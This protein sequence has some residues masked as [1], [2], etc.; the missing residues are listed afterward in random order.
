MVLCEDIKLGELE[1]AR[2]KMAF[3]MG[4]VLRI[5]FL[6][7]LVALLLLLWDNGRGGIITVKLHTDQN[8]FFIEL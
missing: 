5:Y 7:Y 2:R 1:R 4:S 6:N 3:L 8:P